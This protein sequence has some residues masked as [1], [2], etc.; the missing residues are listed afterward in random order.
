MCLK[1]DKTESHTGYRNHDTSDNL[2]YDLTK[3]NYYK[4]YQFRNHILREY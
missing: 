1:I 4:C 3:E 2:V